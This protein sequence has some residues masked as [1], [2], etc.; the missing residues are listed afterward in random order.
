MI[1]HKQS[2]LG[3]APN[4]EALAFFYFNRTDPSRNSALS[5]LQSLVRQISTPRSQQGH[6]QSS[7]RELYRECRR[8]GRILNRELCRRQLIESLNV[9]PRTTFIVDALDECDQEDR[10]NLIGFFDEL[11]RTSRRPL[12]IFISGRP[13]GDIRAALCNR[14]IVEIGVEDNQID[15]TRFIEEKV[16]SHRRW[17]R[18]DKTLKDKVI[19]TLLEK[20]HGM[21]VFLVLPAPAPSL[22]S[23][24]FS[25]PMFVLTFTA[26]IDAQTLTNKPK[27]CYRFRWTK[28]QIDQLL[29]LSFPEDVDSRL[30]KLPGDLK[31]AY[32]EMYLRRDGYDSKVIGRAI[33]WMLATR[34]PVGTEVLLSAVRIDPIIYVDTVLKPTKPNTDDSVHE[35]AKYISSE[36][37]TELLLDLCANF[38]TLDSRKRWQFCHASVSEYFE[39][40][41]F[42]LLQAH[43]H[44]AFVCLVLTIDVWGSI[45]S[46]QLL[47]AAKCLWLGERDNL[48]RKRLLS[49]PSQHFENPNGSIMGHDFVACAGYSWFKYVTL[50]E[51]SLDLN[52]DETDAKN[53][54]TLVTKHD[55]SALLREFLGHPNESSAAYCHWLH[56]IGCG[57]TA[58][59]SWRS[60]VSDR[61]ASFTMVRFGIFK[62]LQSWWPD[63]RTI[64]EDGKWSEVPNPKFLIDTTVRSVTGWD[65]LAFAC[66]FGHLSIVE[67]LLRAG[68]KANERNKDDEYP[69]YG[70][71]PLTLAS[72]QGHVEICKLL[73][74][75]EG[76]DPNFPTDLGNPLYC[77]AESN[78]LSVL[79]YLLSAGADP[80]DPI[81]LRQQHFNRPGSALAAAAYNGNVEAM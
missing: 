49:W 44:A 62:L 81:K 22:V 52:Y 59:D 55:L 33:M 27:L 18:F 7:L 61:Y 20:S 78:R 16:R 80:S 2:I 50:V 28:L 67:T 42:S 68:M 36:V 21:S 17:D 76:C 32:D 24:P 74:E 63:A 41:H 66:H 54:H 79:R 10:E 70:V 4:D 30:G 72:K 35:T 60:S 37:D 69:F 77:A 56:Q 19:N 45:K 38:L 29:T 34:E 1:D 47:G 73:I 25:S 53:K 6:I 40:N 8:G 43:I 58:A 71:L 31:A 51:N 26:S 13:E 64:E 48:F 11:M 23:L 65:L 3:G 39:D 14:T 75:R 5:C 57:L 15:I 9:F 46:H 12:L